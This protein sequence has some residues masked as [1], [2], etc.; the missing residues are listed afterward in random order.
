MRVIHT[1]DTF[2]GDGDG[3]STLDEIATGTWPRDNYDRDFD[4]LWGFLD[5]VPYVND[6][7]HI[8]YYKFEGTHLVA[9]VDSSTAGRINTGTP[10]GNAKPGG[11]LLFLDGEDKT[12][13]D[14]PATDF[15]QTSSRTVHMHFWPD[16]TGGHQLLY[17]EGN[18]TTGLSIYLDDNTLWVGAWNQSDEKFLELGTISNKQWYAV[19]LVFKGSAGFLCGTLFQNNERIS[20]KK[21]AIP[22][23]KVGDTAG[24]VTLGGSVDASRFWDNTTSKT[25]TVAN[26]Y[27]KGLVEDF[28]VYNRILSEVDCIRL[29]HSDLVPLKDKTVVDSDGD[30]VPDRVDSFPNDPGEWVDT[31]GD[32]TGDNADTDDDNDG[33]ADTSDPY[34]KSPIL[35]ADI[36]I[37]QST[38]VE[39][40][41]PDR[42]FAGAATLR[43]RDQNSPYARVPLIKIDTSDINTNNIVSAKLHLYSKT[44]H[45]DVMVYELDNNWDESTVTWN[46]MPTIGAQITSAP[47]TPD[48]WFELD[49][50]NYITGKRI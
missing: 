36:P 30:N 48:A 34:P 12:Y 38:Y 17:K 45:C 3:V 4:G 42:N 33:I 20:M 50:S 49:L 9:I 41:F 19:N 5:P 29:S 27:F 35:T 26:Q 1:D 43:I 28:M 13:V 10:K 44:I 16:A 2:D 6:T 21:I 39:K 11:G 37:I 14:I 7:E 40:H 15:G 32:G 25:I 47:A 24:R 8:V 18:T 23:S 46:T 22:F 31:D